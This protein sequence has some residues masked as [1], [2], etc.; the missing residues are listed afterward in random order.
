MMKIQSKI[1]ILASSFLLI[2]SCSKKEQAVEPSI[3]TTMPGA[4]YVSMPPT[5]TDN[6]IQTS[7]R[8]LKTVKTLSVDIGERNIGK[9]KNLNKAS[10]YIKGKLKNQGYNI[11]S[12]SYTYKNHTVE[13]IYTIKPAANKTDKVIVVGAHYDSLFGTVGANDNASGI[14]VLLELAK[15]LK[16]KKL[17]ANIHFVAFANEEPPYFKTENMGSVIYAKKLRKQKENVIAMY[18]LETMGAYYDNK[19][20]QQYPFPLGQYYP[21]VGNFIAFVSDD[22]SRTLL[23]DSIK[24]FRDNAEIPSEGLSAPEDLEGVS[25]SDHWAFWQ[26]G[27]PALM[28]T[29]TAPFRYEH[30]HQLTDT[31]EKIDYL[32]MSRVTHGI[33]QMLQK[34]AN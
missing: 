17:G 10:N 9:I 1:V 28:I 6:L 29:D 2:A 4:S 24:L 27:Y 30:Y 33:S 15:I 12:N 8:L 13:N 3:L 21:D 26:A 22:K 11:E 25:W 18:S 5:P 23:K 31:Y 14:A 19:G 7:E 20:S 16:N 34:I 32:R